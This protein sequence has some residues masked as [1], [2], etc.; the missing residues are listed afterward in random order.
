MEKL[1]EE[2]ENDL[3]G[4]TFFMD[5]IERQEADNQ[6]FTLATRA[7][8]NCLAI[9]G[10]LSLENHLLCI[11]F[12]KI[13]E[14]FMYFTGL[15]EAPDEMPCVLTAIRRACIQNYSE[16][17]LAEHYKKDG[18]SEAIY[19]KL[20][21]T[22]FSEIEQFNKY[23]IVG[24]QIDTPGGDRIDILAKDIVSKRPVIIELKRG[25][26][27][28][29]KQLRSYAIHYDNPILINISVSAVKRKRQDI[30]YYTFAELNGQSEVLDRQLLIE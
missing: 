11:K 2:Y 20:L 17:T 23:E 29:H 30:I 7:F 19:E 6:A 22:N 26:K 3:N 1:I 10:Y 5:T 24:S 27:S 18:H 15:D 12:I 21:V 13:A 8:Y 4:Y 14:R 16:K 28:G 9:A 25:D